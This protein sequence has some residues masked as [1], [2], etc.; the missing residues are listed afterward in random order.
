MSSKLNAIQLIE[1]KWNSTHRLQEIAHP[2]FEEKSFTSKNFITIDDSKKFQEMYGIG[3]AF[4]EAAAFSLSKLDKNLQE[5]VLE[6]Y[7]SSQSGNCYNF[8]RTHI[9]SCDFSLGNYAYTE[10]PNDLNLKHFSLE[11]DHQHLIPFIK[12]ATDITGDSMILFASPWSPPAWMKTSN[13]M[14]HGGKLREEHREVWANYYCRYIK[15]YQKIGINIWGITVQ[16]EPEAVQTW[17]SCIYSAEEERDFIRDHLGPALDKEGLGYIKIIIW[18]HNRDNVYERGKVV[19]SDEEAAKYVYGTGFHWYE[20]ENCFDN[21]EKLHQ[22]FPDKKLF[23]TEGCQEGGPHLHS[24]DLGE[25]YAHNMINDFNRWTCAWTDWN[26][27]L[28]ETGGP[29]HVNN[30]CSAPIIADTKNNKI[31]YQSSYYYIGHFSKYIKRGAYRIGCNIENSSLEAT[32]FINPDGKKVLIVL[33]TSLED[34][35]LVIKHKDLQARGVVPP[36]SIQ[37]YI[38]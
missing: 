8:C 27:V 21:L 19:L 1:T 9:N 32:A 25:R 24:W 36:R 23:F 11:R 5:E 33:N 18:D 29:N 35:S 30:L 6:A 22:D 12:K 17:D 4:T 26:L 16:N 37:T 34:Q 10:T 7:F 15:E 20:Q 14:N 13:Q 28:D 3:G 38:F 2:G 31:I